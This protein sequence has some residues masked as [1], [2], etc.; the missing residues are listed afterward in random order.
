MSSKIL[1]LPINPS[2]RDFVVGDIHFKTMD[3]H[4]GLHAL[5][6]DKTKDRVIAVGD[7]IDRGPGVLDGLKL[8]GEPWFYTVQGNH[9]RMLIDAYRENPLA[10]YA[11][12]G[13][14][15]WPTI[16]DES[17]GMIIDKLSSL[18]LAIEIES[19]NGI[20]GI[21]HADVPAGVTW[22][23]FLA[24]LDNQAFEDVALWGRERVKKHFRD[25][26]SE[27]WRVCTGHTWVPRP[28]RLGNVLALDITGGGDGSLA[29]YC[30]QD[31]MTYI[32]GLPASLDQAERLTEKLQM[33]EKKAQQLK[34]ALNGNKLIESQI[35]A[36]TVDVTLKQVTSM[37][38]QVQEGVVEQQ[39]LVNALHGLSL[40]NGERRSAMLDELCSKHAGSQTESLL[41]RL[42]G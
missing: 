12:H 13:A 35:H 20:V 29:I 30:V 4:R 34:T 9:E 1:R 8:L 27:V 10:R 37:W 39:K 15:W 36:V 24:E 2:G 17:K 38:L 16:A 26:V 40:V 18:P 7:L 28:L 33:L 6:F 32:D 23:K 19:S 21:V 42:L 14:G 5:G 3:L 31:D 41:R 22:P 11:A 25:G